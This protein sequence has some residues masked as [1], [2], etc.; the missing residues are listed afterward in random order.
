MNRAEE[1]GGKQDANFF[2]LFLLSAL[3]LGYAA[4]LNKSEI[5]TYLPVH[6]AFRSLVGNILEI[7]RRTTT[8]VVELLITTFILERGKEI[9]LSLCRLGFKIKFERE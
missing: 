1:V 8:M 6:G 9:T 3:A 4:D 2:S 5:T 7:L